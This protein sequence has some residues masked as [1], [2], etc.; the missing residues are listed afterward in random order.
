MDPR[1]YFKLI[2]YTNPCMPQVE[3]V[4]YHHI[5]NRE[6]ERHINITETK[7]YS[8]LVI[9]TRIDS[10]KARRKTDKQL[11]KKKK[12]IF[13]TRVCDYKK[14]DYEKVLER[15]LKLCELSDLLIKK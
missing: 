12:I 11:K 2:F 3:L 9:D 6:S 5:K 8:N 10:Y 1:F 15:L 14:E 13:D 7:I 4:A